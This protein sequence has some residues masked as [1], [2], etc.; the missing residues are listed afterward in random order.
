MEL[1][2]IILLLVIAAV[3]ALRVALLSRNFY[4]AGFQSQSDA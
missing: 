4:A 3:N 1:I 2:I